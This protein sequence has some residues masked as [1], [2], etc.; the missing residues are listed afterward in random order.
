MKETDSELEDD[1][2][3]IRY[4]MGERYTPMSRELVT[5]HV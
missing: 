2:D 5:D 1:P 3:P 4:T